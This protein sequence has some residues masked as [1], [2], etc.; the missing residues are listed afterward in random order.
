MSDERDEDRTE[1]LAHR[2]L[3]KAGELIPTTEAE[4]LRAEAEL[5]DAPELPESL[6]EFREA[7]REEKGSNVRELPRRSGPTWNA[8]SRVV[9]VAAAFVLLAV[10]IWQLRRAPQVDPNTLVGG[11]DEELRPVPSVEKAKPLRL[12]AIHTSNDRCCGGSSCAEAPADAKTC[13]SG[14]Q[15]VVCDDG[16]STQSRYRIRLGILAP[17]ETA[18]KEAKVSEWDLCVSVGGAPASCVSE[19]DP[20]GESRLWNVLPPVVSAQDLRAG[21]TLEVRAKGKPTML[22]SWSMPV[23]VDS[24]VLCRGLSMNP[25]WDP[26]GK[27]DRVVFGAVSAFLDDAHYVELG[28]SERVA[29]L[30][31]LGRRI[32]PSDVKPQVFETKAAGTQHFVYT[33]GPLDWKAA[34]R[35][36]WALLDGGE[37]PV[38]TFGADYVGRARP[39]E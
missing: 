36:R 29:E 31:E 15:W 19:Q 13:S 21:V 35:V 17:R 2:A 10:G 16:F 11:A 26:Y 37:R 9:L 7:S 22:A 34:E 23:S 30:R 6:R 24:G 14:R 38:L 20:G 18:L 32:E 1:A 33:V 3:R 39:E 25:S 28:R 4:V 5:G 12:P 27:G 8:V